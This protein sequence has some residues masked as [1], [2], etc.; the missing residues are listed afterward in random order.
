[1]EVECQT[2]F[3]DLRL[4]EEAQVV[5]LECVRWVIVRLYSPQQTAIRH[6]AHDILSCNAPGMDASPPWAGGGAGGGLWGGMGGNYTAAAQ[7]LPSN[8]AATTAGAKV[9]EN[10]FRR[11]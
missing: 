7:F 3:D 6:C 1:M 5:S 9:N 11:I 10:R 4:R 8:F 2:Y